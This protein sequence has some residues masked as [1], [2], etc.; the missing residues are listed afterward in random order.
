MP[1]RGVGVGPAN[2]NLSLSPESV[3]AVCNSCHTSGSR[4]SFPPEKMSLISLKVDKT[5][6]LAAMCKI[7]LLHWGDTRWGL[8]IETHTMHLLLKG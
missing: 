5:L 3:M 1:P 7:V 6:R 2:V 4:P 8:S